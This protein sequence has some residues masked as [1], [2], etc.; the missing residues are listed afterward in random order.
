MRNVKCIPREPR[1]KVCKISSARISKRLIIATASLFSI[2]QKSP[3]RWRLETHV[4]KRGTA[5]CRFFGIFDLTGNTHTRAG[6]SVETLYINTGTRTAL[7]LKR[8]ETVFF[9]SLFMKCVRRDRDLFFTRFGILKMAQ[10]LH[11][12]LCVRYIKRSSL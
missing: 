5:F 4:A 1:G 7:K 11:N 9:A 2:W 6:E 12:T 3:V 10:L 8:T